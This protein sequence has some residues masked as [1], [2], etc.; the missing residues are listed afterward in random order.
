MIGSIAAYHKIWWRYFLIA[1]FIAVLFAAMS[2]RA[3][4]CMACRC[5]ATALN[6][7]DKQ[8]Y[9]EHFRE[10]INEKLQFLYHMVPDPFIHL[11]MALNPLLGPGLLFGFVLFFTQTEGFLGGVNNPSQGRYLHAGQYKH[12]INAHTDIH[13]FE[14]ISSPRS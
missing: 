6:L 12:R 10:R 13:A 2:A 3:L 9:R 14:W 11:S 8:V 4:Q 7:K 1:W 5:Y